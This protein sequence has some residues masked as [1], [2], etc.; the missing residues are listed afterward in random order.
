MG[1]WQERMSQYESHK[2]EK[3]QS[4]SFTASYKLLDEC[5]FAPSIDSSTKESVNRTYDDFY[6]D[7]MKFI[8]KREEKI[9]KNMK[10]KEQINKSA[11]A[12]APLVDKNSE[13]LLGKT[14][15]RSNGKSVYDHLYAVA[16]QK[17]QESENCAVSTEENCSFHPEINESSHQLKRTNSVEIH[18]YNDAKHRAVSLLK[19][20]RLQDQDFLNRTMQSPVLY[21][22]SS[23]LV[24]KFT[25]EFNR[26]FHNISR[27]NLNINAKLSYL[28]TAELMANLG[29]VKGHIIE[30]RRSANTKS[31]SEGSLL[32]DMWLLLKGEDLG[33]ASYGNLRTFLLAVLGLHCSTQESSHAIPK[34]SWRDII[35]G[36]CTIP[37]INEEN[38]NKYSGDES[39]LTKLNWFRSDPTVLTI[40]EEDVVKIHQYFLL[41]YQ[42]RVLLNNNP[43]KNTTQKNAEHTFKPEICKTSRK[44]AQNC[45]NKWMTQMTVSAEKPMSQANVSHS[46]IMWYKSIEYQ[47]KLEKAKHLRL[48]EENEN[49]TFRTEINAQ[50]CKAKK[51]LLKLEKFW[52]GVTVAQSRNIE[53]QTLQESKSKE[54]CGIQPEKPIVK[55]SQP[56]RLPTNRKGEEKSIERMRAARRVF[57]YFLK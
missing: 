39:L 47:N 40:V 15:R 26:A 43:S 13:K 8:Q 46:D 4:L 32:Y 36:V 7:Q 41:F 5:T 48:A 29:F 9:T 14:T 2:K 1:N 37:E 11:L 52:K 35:S 23:Y 50:T 28:K 22:S 20:A 49:L 42:N 51:S 24:N 16:K 45:A 31:M 55:K 19:N 56:K 3:L 27:G 44:L 6:S 38:E 21:K 12:F 33:G 53:M 10:D 18:L 25:N 17:R 30:Y 54:N 34:G 57:P